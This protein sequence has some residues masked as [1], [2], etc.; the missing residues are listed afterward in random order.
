MRRRSKLKRNAHAYSAL[1]GSTIALSPGADI[2]LRSA[3]G[4]EGHSEQQKEDAHKRYSRPT[5]AT[6]AVHVSRQG[7]V[8]IGRSGP[9]AAM[10]SGVAGFFEPRAHLV[11]VGLEHLDQPNR[12]KIADAFGAASENIESP[13]PT[14]RWQTAGGILVAQRRYDA[15]AEWVRNPPISD[16]RSPHPKL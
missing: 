13:C 16:C 8:G 10:R 1:G 14:T 15:T 9:T 6:T 5:N 11:F 2:R 12:A 7:F 4:K 3:C